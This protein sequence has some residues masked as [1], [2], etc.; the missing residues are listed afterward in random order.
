[1]QEISGELM[2]VK[3]SAAYLH[4]IP[5]MKHPPISLSIGLVRMP[6]GKPDSG[7]VNYSRR[8]IFQ[9]VPVGS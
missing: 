8:N 1:M 5:S 7:P 3:Y 2:R 6:P 9:R 4:Y